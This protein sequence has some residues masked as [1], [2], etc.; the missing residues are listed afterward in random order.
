VQTPAAAEEIVQVAHEARSDMVIVARARDADHATRLYEAGA[1][2]A[3]PE[4]IEASMQLAETVLVDIGVP[5]G[6]VIASIHEKR[7]EYRE[8][9]KPK[10]EAALQR[11]V[12][13]A[14]TRK[15][16]M[17]RRRSGAKDSSPETE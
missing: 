12:A 17:A 13:R 11:Q 9:L 2:D 1:S 14:A 15:R 10:E 6:F 7:D 5:M 3:V 4:T 16:V 8:L